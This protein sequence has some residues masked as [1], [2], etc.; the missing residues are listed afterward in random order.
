VI[1][2][3]RK[4][5]KFD[6]SSTSTAKVPLLASRWQISTHGPRPLAQKGGYRSDVV[7]RSIMTTCATFEG[8]CA[9][10]RARKRVIRIEPKLV[11]ELSD[12][13]FITKFAAERTE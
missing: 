5:Q 10:F 8:T 11:L 2:G 13:S 4:K 1:W 3:I 6:V 7:A 9:G 12:V